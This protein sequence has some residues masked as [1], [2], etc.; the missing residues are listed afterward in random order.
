[1]TDQQLFSENYFDSGNKIMGQY[2]SYEAARFYPA[3]EAMTEYIMRTIKLN[4]VLDIGCA[5]G[6]L[7]DVFREKGIEAFGVDISKYAIDQSPIKI[8][9]FVGTCDLNNE[10][11]P[12]PDN[13]FDC[14]ICM[15]TLEYI[16]LQQHALKE[17]SRVLMKGG[18]LLMTTLDSVPEGDEMRK[19]ARSKNTWIELFE[20]LGFRS[21]SALATAV[22]SKYV[23]MIAEFE[24]NRTLYHS[25]S[26]N[27][28]KKVARVLL[29]LGAKPL[30]KEYSLYQQK[31]SG[32]LMLAFQKMV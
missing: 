25:N 23:K 29:S 26:E 18:I 10:V 28:K 14:I 17:I 4:R 20:K 1:M 27:F 9:S 32:Y 22:F 21:D 5:K 7:V 8:R 30:M 19:Y 15:G 12:Y 31:K 16:A 13:Y 3:F 6:Y 24:I 2:A 11:L